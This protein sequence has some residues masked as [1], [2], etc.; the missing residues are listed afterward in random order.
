MNLLLVDD[1]RLMRDGVRA[2]LEHEPDLHV[3]GEAADGRR[4]VELAEK[5]RPDLVL[6]D[7]SMPGLS[8]VEATRRLQ[9]TLPRTRVLGLSMNADRRYV[10]AMFEA[11]AWGY[12]LKSAASDELI[13]AVRSVAADQKYVSPAIAGVVVEALVGGPSARDADPLAELSARE[14]EVLQLIAEGHTS[15]QIADTLGVAASTIET[16]RKQLTAKLQ[17][18]SVA[19]LTKLAVRAGLTPLG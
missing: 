1:H 7:I 13:R 18:R 12:M 11:G 10:Q 2:L 4:A 5:L 15:K 8:G 16:H 6:M 19:E 3:V 9:S 14:R 17:V